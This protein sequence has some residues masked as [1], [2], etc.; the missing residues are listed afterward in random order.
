MDVAEVLLS[1]AVEFVVV[2]VVLEVVP[3]VEEAEEL[4]SSAVE[5]V[6]L[7][8]VRDELG[9]RVARHVD[10]FRKPTFHPPEVLDEVVVP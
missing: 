5:L 6:V 4:L 9:E 2:V 1:S 10:T 8:D 3:A 7:V